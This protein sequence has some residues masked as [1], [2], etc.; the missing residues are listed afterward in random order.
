M[1]RDVSSAGAP[2][3]CKACGKSLTSPT[4]V[5]WE[6]ECGVVVCSNDE[7]VGEYFRFVGGGEGTRCLTCG[8]LL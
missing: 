8:L 6:C 3:A 4:E 7:C 1:A 5:G 2:R